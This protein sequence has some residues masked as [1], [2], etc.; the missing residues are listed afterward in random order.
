[1]TATTDKAP[2]VLIV[3]DQPA[4]IRLLEV[5][6]GSENYRTVSASDGR[7]ALEQAAATHPDVILLD[8]MM[9]R[10]DGYEVCRQ[11]KADPKLRDI[12]IVFLSAKDR[13]QD[14]VEGLEL[15]A[16]DYLTK[17]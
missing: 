4:D 7:S 9:P 1:M 13:V 11:L 17:P 12:P 3:D 10:V 16:H 6:L 2:L 15:G 14:K 5:Y 8:I